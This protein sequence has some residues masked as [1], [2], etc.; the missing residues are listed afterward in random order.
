MQLYMWTAAESRSMSLP[1]V[2]EGTFEVKDT[3]DNQPIFAVT[4]EGNAWRVIPQGMTLFSGKT[5]MLT[6]DTPLQLRVGRRA[7]RMQLYLTKGGMPARRYARCPVGSGV[8]LTIG[9]APDN[10]IICRQ[11]YMAP[12]HLRLTSQTGGWQLTILDDKLGAYIN[13]RRAS[14]GLLRAGDVVS[15]LELKLIVVPGL[16]AFN[17]PGEQTHLRQGSQLHLMP[18]PP[19]SREDAFVSTPVEDFYYRAPRFSEGITREAISVDSPPAA[20]EPSQTNAILTMAPSLLSGVVSLAVATNPLMPLAALAGA[21]IFPMLNRHNAE[22][23][24]AEDEIKRKEAYKAYLDDIERHIADVT[25]KQEA[26][27][28]RMH[29]PLEEQM[30][31]ALRDHRLWQYNSEQADYLELRLGTGS[32]PLE[33]DITFPQE[34]FELQSDPMKQLMQELKSRERRLEGVPILLTLAEFFQVGITGDMEARSALLANLLI[35]LTMNYG[36]DELKLCFIGK[37]LPELE[38]FMWL[39]HTWDNAKQNHY[40]AETEDELRQLLPMLDE[41]LAGRELTHH[42]EKG[43]HLPEAGE[44]ELIVVLFE[45]RVSQTGVVTRLLMEKR[46]RG[47]RVIT[48]TGESRRLPRRCD[49]IVSLDRGCGQMIWQTENGRGSRAFTPDASALGAARRLIYAMANTYLDLPDTSSKLPDSVPFLDLFGVSDVHALNVLTR[50]R[51]NN[52]TVSLAAPIG[53]DE[54]GGLCC[55]DVHEK[56][57]GQ[58]GLIAGTTGSGK[59]ELIMTYILSLAVNFS[60]EEVTFLL[61]DYKGGGMATAFEKLPH[62]AG[63]ITNLD[64]NAVNRSLLAIQSE[65][66]RRQAVFHQAEQALDMTGMNIIKYQRLY[67]EKRVSTPLP[68]L[69]IISDEFAELKTQEPEFMQKLISASRIGRS[70]G[71]HLILA[72]Q[73]PAGVVDDQIWSN[74]NWR[75]CLRVQNARDSQD[76]IKCPDAAT[77]SKVGRFYIQV[78]YGVLKQAQSGFTG[79]PYVPGARTTSVGGVDVL[80]RLG[81]VLGHSELS[82]AGKSAKTV[83]QINAVVDYLATVAQSQGLR[84]QT[85]W[86]PPL[87]P[88]I[89]LD[90]IRQRYTVTDAPYVLEPILGE[91]DDPST[92]SRR[93]L[94][95]NL[96][97][98][99]NTMVYGTVG[100]GKVMLLRAVLEDLFLHHSP[101]E[102]H[103]YILDY[104]DDGLVAFRDVPQVGDVLDTQDDEKLKFLQAYLKGELERR[105]ELVGGRMAESTLAER[106]QKAGLPNILVVLH[107]AHKLKD[108]LG[109]DSSLMMELLREGPRYGIVFL[110]TTTSA[111]LLG[112]RFQDAFA[113]SCVLQQEKKDDYYA[114]VGRLEGFRLE[115]IRGRGVIR[116]DTLCEYQTAAA[117]HEVSELCEL[118]HTLYPG[119]GAPGIRTLPKR[120]AAAD[121]AEEID[122]AVP[123]RIPVGMDTGTLAP[124]YLDLR[125]RRIHLAVGT[126]ADACSLYSEALPLLMASGAEVIVWNPVAVRKMEGVRYVPAE[127]QASA[128]LLRELSQAGSD[129]PERLVVIPSMNVVFDVL[130]QAKPE[131]SVQEMDALLGVMSDVSGM[132]GAKLYND[133]EFKRF[134]ERLNP[135]SRCTFLVSMTDQ[136]TRSYRSDKWYTEKIGNDALVL[137]R[138]ISLMQAIK[139]SNSSRLSSKEESFPCGFEVVDTMAHK[140]KLLSE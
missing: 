1:D 120:I 75:L 138:G 80:D 49:V 89:S 97:E 115:N 20:H 131:A 44:P 60:P 59:S 79:A 135:S 117:D 68:H 21:T 132:A 136:G 34:R 113:R 76:I 77:I 25:A 133:L 112:F 32:V 70:L 27:L 10:E 18:V 65:L 87:D 102:L 78:G 124:V 63:I 7:E 105:K 125:A 35:Q 46:Y 22:K 95:L 40:L 3:A 106:L 140:I 129:A 84:A 37:P 103:T 116:Q 41:M 128:A 52:P 119:A 54:D 93:L 110:G 101:E 6:L 33:Y 8:V 39:P 127:P 2:P 43:K 71:V 85:I 73:R 109:D 90:D 108:K 24:Q 81:R 36:Y 14:S 28:R 114:L 139:V 55:L 15:V 111:G 107:H 126:E 50:W 118:L 94:R 123:W 26:V 100:A 48:V 13:G 137:G 42:M 104:G 96:S 98:G 5:A 67:R 121:L 47:L 72:T 122:P 86:L 17:S 16:L 62:T 99:K 38:R 57:D 53:I 66:V 4:A 56:G 29:P 83:Y 61:I 91:I 92:Q 134:L 11:P 58:H 9:S 23:Q 88:K 69:L 31:F 64:G 45:D 19:I 82:R 12:Y 51:R 74:T 130:K 30:A